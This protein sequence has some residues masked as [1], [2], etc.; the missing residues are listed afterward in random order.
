[1]PLPASCCQFSPS[2]GISPRVSGVLAGVPLPSASRCLA[3]L[4]RPTPPRAPYSRDFANPPKK[5]AKKPSL[6]SPAP[7][8]PG[9]AREGFPP[10][11]PGI[12]TLMDRVPR[13]GPVDRGGTKLINMAPR[14]RCE[15]PCAWPMRR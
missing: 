5:S 13:A 1:M 15:R 6:A 8:G 4:P 7:M 2:P 14:Q 12:D 3:S 11:P 9:L 10:S